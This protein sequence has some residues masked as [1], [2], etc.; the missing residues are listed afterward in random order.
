MLVSADPTM[1]ENPAPSSP[2]TSAAPA[3]TRLC[4]R[5]ANGAGDRTVGELAN[6]RDTLRGQTLGH[7]IRISLS[8]LPET[9]MPHRAFL[10]LAVLAFGGPSAVQTHAVT[11]DDFIRAQGAFD[12]SPEN[13]TAWTNGRAC[14]SSSRTADSGSWRS[15]APAPSSP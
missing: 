5:P 8:S 1:L 13:Q 10:L 2:S 11:T 4:C 9:A 7:S 14:W 15:D 3:A 6:E 12:M